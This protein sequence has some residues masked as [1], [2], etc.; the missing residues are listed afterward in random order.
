MEYLKVC[1]GSELNKYSPSVHH[2]AEHIKHH[3]DHAT[4]GLRKIK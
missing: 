2:E 3:I 1:K 4:Y